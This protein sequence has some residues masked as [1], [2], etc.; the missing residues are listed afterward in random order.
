M[1]NVIHQDKSTVT[2]AECPLLDLSLGALEHHQE[3]AN[4]GLGHDHLVRALRS[5]VHTSRVSGRIDFNFRTCLYV[6]AHVHC[7]LESIEE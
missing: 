4:S 1:I 6:N 7:E 2:E 5:Y 3:L